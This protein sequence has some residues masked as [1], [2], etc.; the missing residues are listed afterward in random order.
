[1]I[2][3]FRMGNKKTK[4]SEPSQEKIWP[5]ERVLDLMVEYYEQTGTIF[6][7]K[8][9]IRASGTDEE[10]LSLMIAV[11]EGR[12]CSSVSYDEQ[13]RMLKDAIA[14]ETYLQ[15]IKQRSI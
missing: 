6:D 7:S 12:W 10:I 9:A 15:R 8:E 13:I 1:M 11:I 3:L 2:Y 14:R 4:N 5:E